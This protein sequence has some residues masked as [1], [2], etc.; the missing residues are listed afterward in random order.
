MD[1]VDI[2]HDGDSG[3]RIKGFAQIDGDG[4][5]RDRRCLFVVDGDKDGLDGFI[6]GFVPSGNRHRVGRR[7]R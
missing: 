1:A 5:G 7:R 6:A 4:A 3:E 2:V